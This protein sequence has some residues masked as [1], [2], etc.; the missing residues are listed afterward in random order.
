LKNADGIVISSGAQAQYF[1]EIQKP[2][3]DP[4]S[5]EEI[6][7][8]VKVAQSG[9]NPETK[10]WETQES[11]EAKNKVVKANIRLVPY[12]IHKVISSPHPLFLDCINEC[13]YAILK[14]IARYD[15]NASTHFTTYA[16]VAIRRHVWR[17]IREHGTSV[18]LPIAE[19]MRRQQVEDDI[20]GSPNALDRL[21][22]GDFDPVS[23]VRS[24]DFDFDDG[25]K[26][27]NSPFRDIPMPIDPSRILFDHEMREIAIEAMSHLKDKERL[28]IERRFLNKEEDV[29][30]TLRGIANEINMSGERVRQ[31][32]R[33]ALAKMK[34]F[35]Q[36]EK[37]EDR[38]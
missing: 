38:S 14:C 2:E 7:E 22:K 26:M 19:S 17:F 15:V 21:I 30:N 23:H 28:I 27:H 25:S 18:K 33:D 34:R 24:I 16:Q 5:N 35:I 29:D 32:E 36:R 11:V 8:L 3:Y 13:H 31:I 10:K 4:I 37:G 12:I 1:K 6:K 9:Y 20:Y